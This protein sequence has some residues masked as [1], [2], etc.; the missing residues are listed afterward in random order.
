MRCHACI[1]TSVTSER[2]RTPCIL[3]LAR[4][5]RNHFV[6]QSDIISSVAPTGNGH[7]PRSPP[8]TRAPAAAAAQHSS[9][10]H[11]IMRPSSQFTNLPVV[12]IV[13]DATSCSTR[14]AP[15][16]GST[17][18]SLS[19]ICRGRR[20]GDGIRIRVQSA[21]AIPPSQCYTWTYAIS[22]STQCYRVL[23]RTHEAG[24][25]RHTACKHCTAHARQRTPTHRR[26]L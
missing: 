25:N 3:Y 1:D 9:P 7:G 20:T 14:L 11:G 6:R 5:P 21:A 12:S 2:A 23:A 10:H 17:A 13:T 22:G 4:A 24:S 18:P 16:A 8:T 15:S 26:I 19:Q